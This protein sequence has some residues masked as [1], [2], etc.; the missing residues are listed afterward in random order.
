MHRLTLGLI[1]SPV[2]QGIYSPG[3]KRPALEADDSVPCVKQKAIS[4]AGRGGPYGCETSR[5][6]HFLDSGLTD[7]CEIVSLTRRPP[8]PPGKFQ[9]LISV[10]G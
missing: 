4:V 2:R 7:G 5:L 1:Q 10:R 6:P 9:V 3:R 8:L